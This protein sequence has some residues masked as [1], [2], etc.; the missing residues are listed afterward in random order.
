MRRG[1]AKNHFANLRIAVTSRAIIFQ[2]SGS[3]LLLTIM[4]ILGLEKQTSNSLTNDITQLDL[5]PNLKCHI[6]KPFK[7]VEKVIM[8]APLHWHGIRAATEHFGYPVIFCENFSFSDTIYVSNYAHRLKTRIIVINGIP[9][10]T[11]DFVKNVTLA[12]PSL[13]LGIIYHGTMS[14]SFAHEELPLV[15]EMVNLYRDGLLQ[16]LGFLD[17]GLVEYVASILGDDKNIFHITNVPWTFKRV[18]ASISTV[19]PHNDFGKSIFIAQLCNL[20]NRRSKPTDDFLLEPRLRDKFCSTLTMDVK[21]KRMPVKIGVFGDASLIHKNVLT[22][23]LAACIVPSAEIHLLEPLPFGEIPCKNPIIKHKRSSTSEFISLLG[24]MNINLYVSLTEAFPMVVLESLIRG[25]PCITSSTSSLYDSDKFLS[26]FL[27]VDRLDDASAIAA[28]ILSAIIEYNAITTRIPQLLEELSEIG[29]QKMDSF[30]QIPGTPQRHSLSNLAGILRGFHI[31]FCTYELHPTS[32]GGAGVVIA[33]L[34]ARLIQLDADVTVISDMKPI[35]NTYKWMDDYGFMPGQHTGSLHIIALDA[36][37]KEPPDIADTNIFMKKSEQW[38]E[39]LD[40]YYQMQVFHAVEFPE[41]VGMAFQTILKRKLYGHGASAYRI[42]LRAHGLVQQID[43][44]EK[45]MTKKRTS[46]YMYLMEDFCLRFADTIIM[47]SYSIA[48]YYINLHQLDPSKIVIGNP[49]IRRINPQNKFVSRAGLQDLMVYGKIQELKGSLFATKALVNVM[50]RTPQWKGKVVFA[51]YDTPH[52]GDCG[53]TTSECIKSLIPDHLKA[54]FIFKFQVTTDTLENE[55][56]AIRA[57]I[58]PSFYESFCMAVHEVHQFG[59]PLVLRSIPA[60]L[61]FFDNNTAFFFRDSIG[62]LQ[63]TI[64]AMLKDNIKVSR[65]SQMRPKKYQDP[66]EVYVNLRE[67]L[68]SVFEY[69]VEKTQMDL[70]YNKI[71]SVYAP[72]M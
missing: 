23:I 58:F 30:L 12:I 33:N 57:V 24:S 18:H 51:G 52:F 13:E 60:Y 11:F 59:V 26:S 42:W 65:I 8:I 40:K 16:R 5:V 36:L 71:L 49:P 35:S 72:I 54:R 43:F 4:F 50:E 69:P 68:Y 3:I 17:E 61:D 28:A 41:Y 44:A 55:L 15:I 70:M 46:S 66:A 27:I 31:V 38:A 62:N 64:L 2:I 1:Y 56:V 34:I 20:L 22:Q 39:A 7:T 6:R 19:P 53:S 37:V 29:T 21:D 63:R 10:G 9:P 67:R 14:Q 48:A 47:Q 45:S 25:I 32:N